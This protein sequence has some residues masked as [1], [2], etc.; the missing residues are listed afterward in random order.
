M[1]ILLVDDSP[2]ARMLIQSVISE[3]ENSNEFNF[4]NAE[5][6][7]Y[8]LEILN[9]HKIDLMFL[10]WNMPVM[11]GDKVVD[12]VRESHSFDKLR[13]IMATTEGSKDQVLK[14][15]KKGIN[16]YLVKPFNKESILKSFNTVAARMH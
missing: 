7:Q 15:A 9:N 10:D 12:L 14:M 8:A 3:H 16:G 4:F 1:N 11:N 13:I 6:G 2:V 5:N